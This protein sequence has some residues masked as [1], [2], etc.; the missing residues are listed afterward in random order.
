MIPSYFFHLHRTPYFFGFQEISWHLL[1]QHYW[2]VFVMSKESLCETKNARINMVVATRR[3]TKEAT[4]PLWKVLL[5]ASRPN[6]LAASFTPVLVGHIITRRFLGDRADGRA[7]FLF[8][9][10]ACLIQIGTNLHNDYADFVKG[11]DDENR[12]GQARATQKGWLSPFQ[13]ASLATI[14]L[15]GASIIGTHLAR[16]AGTWMW[17]V[18]VTS[19]FNAVAY[20]GGP[21]PLGWVGLGWV[22]LGYSGL[23]DVF[24]FA[25][26]GVVA[27]LSPYYL[28]LPLDSPRSCPAPL[29]VAA[30]CLG[31][32]ATAIIVVNNLRDRETD[33]RCG[34]R[35]TAVRFGYIFAVR[36]YVN[37]VRWAHILMGLSPLFGAPYAWALVPFLTCPGAVRLCL[38]VLDNDGVVLDSDEA[39]EAAARLPRKTATKASCA[40]SP[41]PTDPSPANR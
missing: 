4:P 32:L 38:G 41:S 20:T 35:T 33:A 39:A 40:L 16:Q 5:L 37:L 6:T 12:V 26:F 21:Y 24:V 2:L 34:K 36:E 17:C 9:L 18:T 22:S 15:V 14:A 28:S 25:Y 10:F 3:A 13:T 1:L 23:G 30:A 19:V 8:W 11:A 7:S 31:F 29:L 27:T